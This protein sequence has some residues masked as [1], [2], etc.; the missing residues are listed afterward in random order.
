MIGL[1]PRTNRVYLQTM[2]DL[3]AAALVSVDTNIVPSLEPILRT[4]CNWVGNCAEKSYA[5]GEVLIVYL[6]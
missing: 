1:W 4:L 5:Q 6:V 2:K 3:L